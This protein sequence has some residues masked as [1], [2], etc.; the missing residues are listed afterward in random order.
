MSKKSKIRT[1]DKSLSLEEAQR[2]KN[3]N[4]VLGQALKSA[5]EQY[6]KRRKK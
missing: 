2:E 4:T 1:F 6:Q 5:D 3:K